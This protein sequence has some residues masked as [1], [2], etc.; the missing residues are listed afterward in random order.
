MMGTRIEWLTPLSPAQVEA[1][2][3]ELVQAGVAPAA[4]TRKVGRPLV[5]SFD[6]GGFELQMKPAAFDLLTIVCTVAVEPHAGGSRV[7]TTFGVRDVAT[8]AFVALVVAI[9]AAVAALPYGAS[10]GERMLFLGILLAAAVG[11]EAFVRRRARDEV[12][13]LAWHIAQR[14]QLVSVDANVPRA[15]ETP[16]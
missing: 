7:R 4:A 14:L 3:R 13:P 9:M 12:P 1:R 15:L 11:A 16:A 10:M 6:D 8:L 5:G 2:L